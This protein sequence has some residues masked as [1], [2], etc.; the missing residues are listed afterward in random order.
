M[1]ILKKEKG[2]GHCRWMWGWSRGCTPPK[3]CCRLPPTY[4][5]TTWHQTREF[6]ISVNRRGDF[7]GWFDN[8]E[9]EY[10]F[11]QNE[12]MRGWSRGCTPPQ[13][14]CRLPPTYIWTTRHQTRAFLITVNN[15]KR[16][17]WLVWQLWKRRR[18]WAMW[19]LAGLI[20]WLHSA[21]EMLQTN[22]CLLS[23]HMAPN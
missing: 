22:A 18:V 16:S 11:G 7:S 9:K 3:E 10:E 13:E 21:S 12:W 8:F 6:L 23:G 2:F 19:A 14:C 4:F 20:S 1:T 15:K 17:F 5:W